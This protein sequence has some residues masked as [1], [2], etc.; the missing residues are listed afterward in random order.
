M[1]VR[2]TSAVVFEYVENGDVDAVRELLHSRKLSLRDHMHSW[3]GDLSL[4]E[5]RK[6]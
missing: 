2:P 6:S 3:D 1:N 4:F 5:V